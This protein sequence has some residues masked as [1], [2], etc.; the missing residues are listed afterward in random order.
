VLDAVKESGV[1]VE[2][3]DCQLTEKRMYCRIMSPDTKLNAKDLLGRYNRPDG[4]NIFE[5]GSL[6]AGI[7]FGNS[8]TGFGSFFLQP[9]L[10]TG[11]CMNGLV[12]KKEGIRYIHRGERLEVGAIEYSD[13]TKSKQME[14]LCA[15]IRDSVKHI[16]SQSYLENKVREVAKLGKEELKHPI[17]AVENT[18]R[19]L[20]LNDEKQKA[21]LNYFVKGGETNRFALSSAV[22]YLAQQCDPDERY[23]LECAS[24]E[25]LERASVFDK[26]SES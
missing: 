20:K 12:Y 1:K 14:A 5:N 16:L 9:T 24:V 17:N 13:E 19:F 15:E 25:V 3:H 22:T 23:E 18:A 10:I 7:T 4:G 6:F 8:E 26:E 21:L 11:V 2:V